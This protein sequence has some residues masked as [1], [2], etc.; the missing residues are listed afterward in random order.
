MAKTWSK[1]KAIDDLINIKNAAIESLTDCTVSIDQKA[2]TAALNSI[3][4]LNSI[5]GYNK[6]EAESKMDR[7]VIKDDI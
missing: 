6:A 1:S 7:V 3:K 4:E 5:C 2:A